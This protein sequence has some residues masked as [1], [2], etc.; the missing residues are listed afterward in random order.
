MPFLGPETVLM[1]LDET[2]L[3]GRPAM[4]STAGTFATLGDALAAH[5]CLAAI[6]TVSSLIILIQQA[7]IPYRC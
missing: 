3:E 2:G 6:E 4:E 7:R 1:G 5:E